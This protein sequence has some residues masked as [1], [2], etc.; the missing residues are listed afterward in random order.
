MRVLILGATGMLGHK[1]CQ[2]CKHHF[3]VWATV[4]SSCHQYADYGIFD[5]CSLVQGVEATNFD[6]V[7]QAFAKARP[8]VV[9]NCIGLIKH[10]PEAKDPALSIAV[11]ASFPHRLAQLCEAMGARLI[12][13]ST[14]CVFAGTKGMYT[15]EDTSDA[16]DLYGR[17]KFLGEVSGTGC[18]TLR[19]SLIG[20]ELRN[21]NGL[22][23]WFLSQQNG[24]V[25]GYSQA[26]FSGLS[27]R[28]MAETIIHLIEEHSALS[29]VFHLA[30]EPID[31][32]R[33]LCLLRSAFGVQIDIEEYPNMR[34]DR[35]LDGSRLRA[36]TAWTPPSWPEM[37]QEMAVD[38]TPY[39]GWAL[40]TN[41]EMFEQVG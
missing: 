25:R 36:I 34:I 23:E 10:L 35:S 37:V 17:T 26:I 5:S 9:V 11:N 27:T 24:V 33:L 7:I 13:I 41:L 18:L 4:R 40:H 12:H 31:K 30:A 38:A 20:R 8:Q 21:S 2:V 6:T 22:A 14:D 1:L 29:G 32:Y 19:T 3:E 39:E 15:E 28:A 16:E